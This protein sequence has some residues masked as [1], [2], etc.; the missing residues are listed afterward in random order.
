MVSDTSS[1]I[2]EFCAL[3]KPIITFKVGKTKRSL[4][5]INQLLKKI[6]IQINDISLLKKAIEESLTEPDKK[7]VERQRANKIMFDK[8]DGRAGKK[9]AE[10]IRK[11]LADI[12]N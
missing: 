7:N 8:L 3:N 12:S 6:S 2:A 10:I 9:A 1:I 4:I 11:K 5:E